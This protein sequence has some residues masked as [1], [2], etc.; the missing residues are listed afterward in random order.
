MLCCFPETNILIYTCLQTISGETEAVRF[1]LHKS[2]RQNATNAT[3]S[4][5]E[6][7]LL[8]FWLERGDS[9]S[10]AWTELLETIMSIC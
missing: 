2:V 10:E 4:V 1:A 5:T 3:S 9:D 8:E 7:L 6:R